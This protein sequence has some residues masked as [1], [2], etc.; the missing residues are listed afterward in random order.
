M[1]NRTDETWHRLQEWTDSSATAERLAAQILM[2]ADYKDLDPIHPLGGKDGR[3][4]ARCT[5]DGQPC[6]MAVYFPRGQQSFATI[7]KKFIEDHAG[8]AANVACSMAFVTNQEIRDAERNDLKDAVDVPV[9]IFHVERLTAILDQPSMHSVRE[10]F[11][12]ISAS[13]TSQQI[14]DAARSDARQVAQDVYQWGLDQRRNRPTW[15]QGAVGIA[16]T[17]RPDDIRARVFDPTFHSEL[18]RFMDFGQLFRRAGHALYERPEWTA[19]AFTLG[20]PLR[21]GDQPEA[22]IATRCDVRGMVGVYFRENVD[23]GTIDELLAWWVLSAWRLGLATQAFL[24]GAQDYFASVVLNG[25]AL[26]KAVRRPETIEVDRGPIR[27]SRVD[28]RREVLNQYAH[29]AVANI[30]S[31]RREVLRAVGLPAY[32]DVLPEDEYAIRD[33]AGDQRHWSPWPERDR[34]SRGRQH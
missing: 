24:G 27:M 7:R 18:A 12:K 9:D 26:K 14:F 32:E 33:P 20:G 22:F 13:G 16:T 10:Q 1:A 8:V 17:A 3:K 34:L 21:R 6:I 30:A 28:S 11:L 23:D 15:L 5:K 29:E 4:D 31:V 19:T 25:R 2:A